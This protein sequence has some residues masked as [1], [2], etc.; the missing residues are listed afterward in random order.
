MTREVRLRD[1]LVG[2]E[3]LAILRNLYYGPADNAEQRI[4]EI[5]RLL[6]DDEFTAG[7]PVTESD[8]ATGYR[9]WSVN[10]D[11]PGNQLIAMEQ[12]AVWALLDAGKPG[13]ALDAACGTGRHTRHLVELGH[14]VTGVDLTPEMLVIAEKSVPQADFRVADLLDL[15]FDDAAFD[16]VVCGLA[17][18]HL[19]D[20][21]AAVAELGRVL[22]PGGR[23]I[24]SS[25]HP[26]QAQLDW[27]APFKDAEGNRG[28]VREHRHGHADYIS[29]FTAAG[30]TVRGC[31]EPTIGM[32]EISAK[33]RAHQHIPD[34]TVAA[35]LGLPAVLVWDTEKTPPSPNAS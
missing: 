34:A 7:E 12:P 33:R 4:A 10:Y 20:L 13:D 18:A 5:R 6:T 26:F 30:L 24:T 17:L 35:Y 29:A 2:V 27:N 1:L 22:R 8:S 15:P 19:P 23:L 16:L 9:L 14:R 28:F 3:G 25:V 21:T 32:T 11:E 31:L